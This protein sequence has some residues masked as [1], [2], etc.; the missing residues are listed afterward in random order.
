MQLVYQ[1]RQLKESERTK[2]KLTP[3][4]LCDRLWRGGQGIY[5]S[6]ASARR[7]MSRCWYRQLIATLALHVARIHPAWN[8]DAGFRMSQV[9]TNTLMATACTC[10]CLLGVWDVCRTRRQLTQ[11]RDVRCNHGCFTQG[12][13][14]HCWLSANSYT[15]LISRCRPVTSRLERSG[16][17][18]KSIS[19]CK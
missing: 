16:V 2:K 7:P 1:T 8:L 17:F 15:Y 11:V 10:P 18:I 12:C 3:C 9:R 4:S 5:D 14:V 13:A 6:A 19:P